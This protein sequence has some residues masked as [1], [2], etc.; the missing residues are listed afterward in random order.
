MFE[1]LFRLRVGDW[2]PEGG[3]NGFLAILVVLSS[4]YYAIR[5]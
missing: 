4:V 2:G 5:F 3:K 1:R